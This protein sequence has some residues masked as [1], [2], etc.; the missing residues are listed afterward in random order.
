MTDDV[1]KKLREYGRHSNIYLHYAFSDDPSSVVQISKAP[2]NSSTPIGFYTYSA[3]GLRTFAVGRPYIFVLRYDEEAPLLE[4]DAVS[5]SELD[6]LMIRLDSL[7]PKGE[8]SALSARMKKQSS[9]L[10]VRV[11]QSAGALFYFTVV[12]C[13]PPGAYD[14]EDFRLSLDDESAVAPAYASELFQELGYE[15][16]VDTTGAIYSS[17]PNQVVFFTTDHLEVVEVLENPQYDGR[18]H[19]LVT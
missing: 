6:V 19:H 16:V 13:A 5:R 9:R 8:L 4:L 17:E 11:K 1:E 15:G 12:K 2:R 14:D 3:Q 18:S 10:P 7:L